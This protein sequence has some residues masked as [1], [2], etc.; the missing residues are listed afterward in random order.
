LS[1]LPQNLQRTFTVEI[2]LGQRGTY[3][4]PCCFSYLSGISAC[5]TKLAG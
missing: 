5:E 3:L 1:F 2:Y 4:Y